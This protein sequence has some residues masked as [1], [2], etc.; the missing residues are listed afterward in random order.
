M[1]RSPHN[2]WGIPQETRT[3]LIASAG[4]P[5]FDGSQEYLFWL[6]CGNSYDPHG[7]AV[8]KAMAEIFT[9]FGVSWG[10]LDAETCCGEPTRRAGNE[11]L[12]LD[13]S[14]RLLGVF[15]QRRVREIVT[16]CPHCTTMFDQD[17]RQLA[18]FSELG[19]RV[20]HHSQFLAGAFHDSPVVPSQQDVA[21][22]D[23]CYLARWN[24]VVDEPRELLRACGVTV[25]EPR[26]NRRDTSCCG[27]GGGQ[28]FVADDS[29]DHGKERINGLRLEE[30]SRA[31]TR[32][33]AVACPYCH[34]MLQD[35]ALQRREGEEALEIKD[36]AEIVADRLRAQATTGGVTEQ[37]GRERST[38]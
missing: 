31:G 2:P 25:K 12:F 14:D 38:P 16:C 26:H 36:L 30:L 32:R 13:L 17:Y 28:I 35:A 9:E 29:Q 11:A 21:Y 3:K 8:A 18:D 19:I 10:V 33:I 5:I 34:I 6:G 27:A 24:G 20:R 23:P 4:F 37:T 15:R 7:Q 22:H 1:E